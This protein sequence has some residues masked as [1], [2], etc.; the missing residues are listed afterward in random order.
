MARWRR[1]RRARRLRRQRIPY[2]LWRAAAGPVLAP[3]RLAGRARVRLRA[4]AGEFLQAKVFTGAR[5]QAIDDAL[6]VAIAAE[7]CLPVLALGLRWYRG[8]REIIVYPGSFV[9]EH[10][11]EDSAGVVHRERRVL[12]G[13]AWDRGPVILA[14]EDVRPDADLRRQGVSL[15][16][17]EFAHKLDMQSGTANGRPPLHPGMDPRRWAEVLSRAYARLQSEA[18]WGGGFIDPYG[19][20]SPAEFFAVASEHFF[21]APEALQREAPELYGQLRLFYRQDPARGLA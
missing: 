6:R 1:G 9:V 4:L 21:L 5:G 16:L 14:W 12:G 2:R 15:V 20:E 11:V 17:H 13:E 8:W 7:A 10:E 19:A 18:E 3:Y